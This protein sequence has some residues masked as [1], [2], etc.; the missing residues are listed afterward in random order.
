MYVNQVQQIKGTS[1]GK[2]IVELTGIEGA[3]R[4]ERQE[5]L[6]R[7]LQS[8]ITYINQH[9][10]RRIWE[11]AEITVYDCEFNVVKISS[12][13]E[14]NKFIVNEK[15]D[16]NIIIKYVVNNKEKDFPEEGS[17]LERVGNGLRGLKRFI[18]F[19][20]RTS[21]AETKMIEL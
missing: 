17:V 3:E 13:S 21:L 16:G 19:L 5:K 15:S 11:N 8:L 9:P 12:G 14:K 7:I 6:R 18:P 10:G 2:A 1:I 20:G 4:D